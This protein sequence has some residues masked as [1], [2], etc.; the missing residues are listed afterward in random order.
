MSA[1]CA[2]KLVIDLHDEFIAQFK[3]EVAESLRDN[4]ISKNIT[5]E[6]SNQIK[7]DMETLAYM[8]A[9]KVLLAKAEADKQNLLEQIA[10][11]EGTVVNTVGLTAL[12]E[13]R[14]FNTANGV[15]TQSTG[16]TTTIEVKGK[17]V[18]GSVYQLM[19]RAAVYLT[20]KTTNGE[21]DNEIN[22][23]L[24]LVDIADLLRKITNP[25]AK[26]SI[27]TITFF[28]EGLLEVEE[29][30]INNFFTLASKWQTGIKKRLTSTSL[31]INP[32]FK[33]K[34]PVQ[35]LLVNG[36]VKDENLV[37]AIAY[38]AYTWFNQTAGGSAF[39]DA[40][41]IL[42]LLGFTANDEYTIT[43]EGYKVLAPL[44]GT[45]DFIIDAIGSHV[46][47][48]LGFRVSKDAPDN[49]LPSLRAALG[50]HA[51][52]SLINEG[53]VE[54]VNKTIPE[55]SILIDGLP[56]EA[57][58]EYE[59]RQFIKPVRDAKLELSDDGRSIITYNRG[60]F[61]AV[62]RLFTAQPTSKE[63]SL[64]P[65]KYLQKK[66]KKT[67]QL[68]APKLINALKRIENVGKKAIPVMVDALNILG[69]E[70]IL[71]AAGFVTDTEK[72]L[73]AEN[74]FGAEAKNESLRTQLAD[75]RW[76]LKNN[77]I[78]QLY[79]T[80][81]EA[82]KNSRV[83]NASGLLNEQS[84]KIVRNL[85]GNESWESTIDLNNQ[86]MVN[87]YLISVAQNL[88]I[89]TDAQ[90][91]ADTLV[92]FENK[93]KDA[94]TRIEEFADLIGKALA[95][96]EQEILTAQDKIDI[97]QFSADNEGMQ[98]LQALV[99]LSQYKKAL[100]TPDVPFKTTL[101]VGVDGKANG[102]MLT[103]LTLGAAKTAKA[104]YGFLNRGGFY[105]NGS[106]VANFNHW[107]SNANPDIY[108]DLFK[109]IVNKIP[110]DSPQDV[111]RFKAL[112]IILKDLIDPISGAVTS[113]GR[114][115][116]KDSQTP[117]NFGSSIKSSRAGV[118]RAV[119]DNL[120][121]RI[122]AVHLAGSESK[123]TI[124]ELITAINTI[125]PQSGLSASMTSEEL[126]NLTF[127]NSWKKG[128]KISVDNVL[129]DA[130]GDT[131]K[132][133][134]ADLIVRRDNLNGAVQVAFNMYHEAF[135]DIAKAEIDRLMDEGVISFDT[136]KSGKRIPQHDLN[137][138]QLSALK[139]KMKAI[140][141][142]THTSFS[143]ITGDS[144]YG[145]MMS[146][147]S[148]GSGTEVFHNVEVYMGE[149]VTGASGKLVSKLPGNS[150]VITESDIG[151]GGVAA[152][153][154]ALDSDI[155]HSVL[156]DSFNGHD[157]IASSVNNVESNAQAINK[158]LWDRVIEFSPLTSAF[159]TLENTVLNI[160]PLV[161]DGSISS[162]TL[163]SFEKFFR[164]QL[165]KEI[166]PKI[167]TSALVRVVLEQVAEQAYKARSVTLEAMAQMG[168]VDQYTWE[169]GEHLV[170]PEER[171]NAQTLLD[172][173]IAKGSGL[174]AE[175]LAVA[176]E[177]SK[178][179]N[180]NK[181]SV[182]AEVVQPTTS[183][184][185]KLGS[186]TLTTNE[187]LVALFNKS[188]SMKV[189]DL[190]SHLDK[191]ITSDTPNANFNKRLLRTLSKTINTNLIINSITPN[192]QE[193]DVVG[194]PEF[195]ANAW[196]NPTNNGTIYVL[197]EEFISS[198]MTIEILLHELIHGATKN[199]I[200]NGNKAIQPAI[201]E[202][203]GLRM[204]VAKY[205]ASNKDTF[206]ETEFKLF[207]YA[208]TNIDELIA[209]GMSNIDFQQKVLSNVDDVAKPT[210]LPI[211]NGFNGFI[212][213]L[214]DLLFG[215]WGKNKEIQKGMNN[216]IRNT[217]A[218]LVQS[219]KESEGKAI[220]NTSS[221]MASP[222]FT[223]S[224]VDIFN[225]LNNSSNPLPS[226]FN[227]H[228]K[229]I[230]DSIVFKLH[231]P[232]GTLKDS[233]MQNQ[234]GTP[235]DVWN[236][237]MNTLQ[238]PFVSKITSS[239]F[240]VSEQEAFVM[241]Q[242]E[243]T[244]RASLEDADTSNTLAYRQLANLYK[245]AY[246]TVK[247]EDFHNNGQGWATATQHEKDKA[248]DLYDFIFDGANSSSPGKRG[249]Y[250]TRF[251]AFGLGSQQVNNILKFNTKINTKTATNLADRL[252]QIFENILS[253]FQNKVTNTFNGQSA[254]DKLEAIVQHLVRI[255]AKKRI[256]IDKKLKGNPLL[257]SVNDRAKAAS[258]SIGK[259]IDDLTN[260]NAIK[261]SKS[262]TVRA[263]GG[264]IGT[265]AGNR[266]ENLFDEM[267]KVRDKM[268]DS[269]IG[270]IAGLFNDIRGPEQ[271]FEDLLVV[272]KI[273]ETT[274]AG[275]STAMKK[276]LVSAFNNNGQ[277]LQAKDKIAISKIF[278]DTG[279]HVLLDTMTINE[280][281]EVV[282][283]ATKLKEVIRLTEQELG[284]LSPNFKDDYVEQANTLGYSIVTG[285]NF[286]KWQLKNSYNISKLIGTS[287]ES[288]ISSSSAAKA[289]PV[290]NKLIALYA[291][292]Y[293][294]SVAR[295]N[296]ATV[297]NTENNRAAGEFNGIEYTLANHKK[298]E[299]ES[300][301]KLFD[302]N[303]T[304]TEHGYTPEILNPNKEI[305]VADAIEGAALIRQGYEQSSKELKLDPD[306]TDRTP[307][308]LYSISESGAQR[309]VSGSIALTTLSARGNPLFTGTRDPSTKVGRTNA[310]TLRDF[311]AKRAHAISAQAT[312]KTRENLAARKNKT[313]LRLPLLDE[314]GNVVN[315]HNQMSTDARDNILNRNNMFD[316]VMSSF[317]GSIFTKQSTGEMNKKVIL[318]AKADFDANYKTRPQSFVLIG[319]QST[320]K[321][322]Q[323][324]WNMLPTETK[325][326]IQTTFTNDGMWIQRDKQDIMFGY[327]KM[328]LGN[329]FKTGALDNLNP[330]EK[331][332]ATL[333]VK[334]MSAA[335]K[336]KA[337]FK[338]FKYEKAWVELV[339]EMKDIIVV[340][341]F[342]VTAGNWVANQY[343]LKMAGISFADMA[344]YQ[345]VAMAGATTYREDK[346]NLDELKVQIESG[347]ITS[348]QEVAKI[349]RKIKILE[350]DLENNPVTELIE[351]GLMPAIVEDL[352][353][354][355]EDFT[356]KSE[357]AKS[358]DK[359]TKKIKPKVIDAAKIAVMAHDTKL[360]QAANRAAQLSDFTARYAMYQHLINKKNPLTKAEATIQARDSFINYDVPMQ[361]SIQY[362]DDAGLIIFTKYFVRI[363]RVLVKSMKENPTGWLTLGL[364]DAYESLPYNINESMGWT[365]IGN[366]PFRTGA[367]MLPDA[368]TKIG[369]FAALDT[370]TPDIFSDGVSNFAP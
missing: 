347:Y 204:R 96:P 155:M 154:H 343:L 54:S 133:Y 114:A 246:A 38:G 203:N 116:G 151:V 367:L 304:L 342:M 266:T 31:P 292:D 303:P 119:L 351:Q 84:S 217:T 336:D 359:W 335:F 331:V 250:L 180:G 161:K 95:N 188:P 221:A 51:L 284:V 333:F 112:N 153:I 40:D 206:T 353:D 341:T 130:V 297:I 22:A 64:K 98:T 118:A 311:T 24:P 94:T 233:I 210:K 107:V 134:Y 349:N 218:I 28:P 330:A 146:K 337:A 167:P 300:L 245:E 152:L 89:K 325:V 234:V 360:Y 120:Y 216:L 249:D 10:T 293:S 302:N 138:K 278:L 328:S 145:K 228:L 80:A 132:E 21:T 259:T 25:E 117:F 195:A 339:Q 124:G 156:N 318:A 368:F 14:A 179:I 329:L 286:N 150:R 53:L 224:T 315:W 230:I 287:K 148:I 177:L 106:G 362:L 82:W 87:T 3:R 225:S 137:T 305:K 99:S 41:A 18:T 164:K 65:I 255:E 327:S 69:D 181:P 262:K 291:I 275:I 236:E 104:L 97:G 229:D 100:A 141:P 17:S 59:L 199:T 37:T 127:D 143:Q 7:S 49:Y 308:H 170:S 232:F 310:K 197:N 183:V 306:D 357:I 76:L 36:E 79:Y 8:K 260:S 70:V 248:Q 279:A 165:P 50:T 344:K 184:F 35:D 202:L 92:I 45:K 185:G 144:S 299:K 314:K 102:P 256:N 19:N 163:K 345:A 111:N 312:P 30:A 147:S 26:D 88:G 123:L 55:L 317:A 66:Y 239:G 109:Q 365:R 135:K 352:T 166:R 332:L 288:K 295:S 128:F 294:D 63:I 348:P 174:S 283:N 205:V 334:I 113:A 358:A 222:T 363:Q 46:I 6:E 90:P 85:F 52:Q 301:A 93:R 91:N 71:Q 9:A 56:V 290:I 131:L 72:N 129:G 307:K 346:F 280:I 198:G 178:L 209:I 75:V 320:D 274:R 29:T 355:R 257:D 1:A 220:S 39:K 136:D 264:V 212:K 276:S 62:D 23:S 235:L 78:D 267:T 16:E 32:L 108:A 223:Y 169:G 103:I 48:A 271:A 254:N 207:T 270:I 268:Y 157:E 273:S 242:I 158:S 2:G 219:L 214:T 115:L 83:G 101:L 340:K 201:S 364:L 182:K 244:V 196:Y 241:D 208:S 110:K 200:E 285:I 211:L 27:E 61:G 227:N 42:A 12:V 252:Q 125:Y 171:A 366:D 122:Q 15:N 191:L 324:L 139:E 4:P 350:I 319:P 77:S 189:G 289:Q 282:N 370:V 126:F 190:I 263:L 159:N 173:H 272:K 67:S 356:Y 34:D 168:S 231:G 43:R 162:E 277:D 187:A 60:S 47:E 193:S 11:A 172:V 369:T 238:L 68:V 323:D 194:K 160:L 121:D 176:D 313:S 140:L 74:R 105:E 73:Q 253:F 175:T 322:S 338:V 296:A 316:D 251:V 261:N 215:D 149:K 58:T 57:G 247:V 237:A 186:P 298:L 281:G 269:Q 86:N 354:V 309:R 243:A 5:K 33:Y 20:Q 213:I 226:T 44:V 192:T 326:D 361:K 265:I 13:G 240:N 321:E 258:Q 81:R 142:L